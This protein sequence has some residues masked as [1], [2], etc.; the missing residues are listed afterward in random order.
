MQV[1]AC[2]CTP[3]FLTILPGLCLGTLCCPLHINHYT[4][5]YCCD[6]TAAYN[7]LC[8]CSLCKLLC[9][10]MSEPVWRARSSQDPSCASCVAQ[11]PIPSTPV[12]LSAML[13]ALQ[14]LTAPAEAH[15]CRTVATGTLPSI[16]KRWLLAPTHQHAKETEAFCLHA[17][18]A[19]MPRDE[20]PCNIRWAT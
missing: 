11:P 2:R 3:A 10:Y 18:T 5:S 4:R 15:L 9:L 20:L 17:K 12:H 7:L 19:A 6:N 1:L 16:Q 14:T 8:A 13:L